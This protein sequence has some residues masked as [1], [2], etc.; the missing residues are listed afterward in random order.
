MQPTGPRKKTRPY[1][2]IAG[3]LLV[4]VAARYQSEGLLKVGGVLVI[5]SV[6]YGKLWYGRVGRF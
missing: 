5:L 2:A 6:L 1:G 3:V 4:W